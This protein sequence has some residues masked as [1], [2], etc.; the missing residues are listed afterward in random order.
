[1][2]HHKWRI[3]ESRPSLRATDADVNMAVSCCIVGCHS[4]KISHF[5]FCIPVVIKHQGQRMQDLYAERRRAWLAKI[6][7]KAPW[8]PNEHARVNYLAGVLLLSLSQEAGDVLWLARKL[9]SNSAT[10]LIHSCPQ[11]WRIAQPLLWTCPSVRIL[12][13]YTYMYI[14]V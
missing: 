10:V 1:M 7:W 9:R 5:V 14:I 3:T 6:N 13:V 12:Y 4:R 2:W 8:K 11:T